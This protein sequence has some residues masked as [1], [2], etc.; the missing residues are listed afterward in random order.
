MEHLKTAPYKASANVSTVRAFLSSAVSRF[1]RPHQKKQKD[2]STQLH[3]CSTMTETSFVNPGKQIE[4][5]SPF[6]SQH[7]AS[8]FPR[9][10]IHP[11]F[12]GANDSKALPL[13]G[14]GHSIASSFT[15]FSLAICL[16]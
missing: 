12:V 8:L 15:T 9:I 4:L 16:R 7:F 5:V 1:V 13:A 10:S 3:F 2:G 11:H 6:P 14:A